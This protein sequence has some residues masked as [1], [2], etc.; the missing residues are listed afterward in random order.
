MQRSVV[1]GMVIGAAGLVG[2]ATAR[3]ETCSPAMCAGMSPVCWLAYEKIMVNKESKFDTVDQCTAVAQDLSG[4]G[5]WLAVKG[6]TPRQAAAPARPPSGASTAACR[7]CP[8]STIPARKKTT[9]TS[10]ELP[11]N[12]KFGLKKRAGLCEL[13]DHNCLPWGTRGDHDEEAARGRARDDAHSRRRDCLGA[14]QEHGLEPRAHGARA[15]HD[16]AVR[17]VLHLPGW[18]GADPPCTPAEAGHQPQARQGAHQLACSRSA[19]RRSR[20]RSTPE[21]AGRSST[22]RI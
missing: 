4:E 13:R 3:A 10:T 6:L 16:R 17:P 8:T 9:A 15:L 20:P 12:A 11:E 18:V 19:P 1:V 14:D 2:A 7:G 5:S 22:V 21:S